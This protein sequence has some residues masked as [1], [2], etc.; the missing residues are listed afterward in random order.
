MKIYQPKKR[1]SPRTIPSSI[2][3]GTVYPSGTSEFTT[4]LSQSFVFLE[5]FCISLFVP[6]PF[7]DLLRLTASD[8]PVWYLQT[9]LVYQSLV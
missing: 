3:A 9:F 1:Y 5:V 6:L 2:G 4:G 7:F 8:Y